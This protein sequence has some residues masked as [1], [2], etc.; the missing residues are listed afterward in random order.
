MT[1]HL[2]FIA[3]A[4]GWIA[5]LRVLSPFVFVGGVAVGL[6]NVWIVVRSR[7]RWWAKLWAVFLAMSLSAVLW[8]ALTFH[9]ILFRA[10]F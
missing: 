10:G 2:D 6:W 3:K 9:L 4:N 7:R 5:L 8:A 1:S